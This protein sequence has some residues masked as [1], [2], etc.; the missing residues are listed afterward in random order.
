M[1]GTSLRLSCKRMKW[2]AIGIGVSVFL[3]L[4][5]ILLRP[6]VS[7]PSLSFVRFETDQS[8]RR[9]A[10]IRASNNSASSFTYLGSPNNPVHGFSVPGRN[11]RTEGWNADV[12]VHQELCE[13]SPH[14][15][16][17][18][19]ILPPAKASSFSVGVYFTQ[20][21]SDEVKLST[22]NLLNNLYSDIRWR[23]FGPPQPIWSDVVR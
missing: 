7:A 14:S 8:G 6:P 20:G 12:R 18:F 19:S 21:N 15:S 1:L 16:F 22:R 23:F 17:E 4:T 10:V 13:L 9:V 11:G 5:Y 3:L 2:A